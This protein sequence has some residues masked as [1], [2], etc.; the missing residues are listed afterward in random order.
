MS[1]CKTKELGRT[2]LTYEHILFVHICI[3]L[4]VSHGDYF[5]AQESS[6][7]SGAAKGSALG[8]NDIIK[9]NTKAGVI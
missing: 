9:G 3:Q 1:V 5:T 8:P 4:V 2:T 6:V 7:M